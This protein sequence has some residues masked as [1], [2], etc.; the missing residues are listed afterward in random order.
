MTSAEIVDASIY[1]MLQVGAIGSFCI[2]LLWYT[3]WNQRQIIKERKDSALARD[4]MY[5]EASAERNKMQEQIIAV[6]NKTN[7]ID[8]QGAKNISELTKDLDIVLKRLESERKFLIELIEK[9]NQIMTTLQVTMQELS[10]YI[11]T[12]NK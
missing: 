5:I 7:D 2:A 9:N 12:Q 8:S 11:R 4:K 3:V 10:I 1:Q 6:L